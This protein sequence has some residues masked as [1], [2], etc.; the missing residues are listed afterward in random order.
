MGGVWC[1]A[2]TQVAIRRFALCAT[3]PPHARL[4][5]P[6][7]GRPSAGIRIT[8][9]K[10]F[11]PKEFLPGIR[12]ELAGQFYRE[13]SYDCAAS[14]APK[15]VY[16]PIPT[17]GRLIFT[18]MGG[19]FTGILKGGLSRKWPL[20]VGKPIHQAWINL[21]WGTGRAGGIRVQKR[22]FFS[23]LRA[24]GSVDQHGAPAWGGA[25]T[26]PPPPPRMLFRWR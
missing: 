15:K 7:L 19:D 17:G 25:A 11:G 4:V 18:W 23:V 16:A 6:F 26:P 20:A 5:G 10:N 13:V 21:P 2:R 8:R 14:S 1:Q 12:S 24:G 9:R 22:P 3:D